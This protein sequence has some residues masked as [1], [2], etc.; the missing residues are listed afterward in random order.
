MKE[1]LQGFNLKRIA[2]VHVRLRQICVLQASEA[3]CGHLWSR[4][5]RSLRTRPYTPGKEI[6]M[7]LQGFLADLTVHLCIEHLGS[8]CTFHRP[9]QAI[10]PQY[11]L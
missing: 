4:A 9:S 5:A 11:V 3:A 6:P 7:C 1:I 8:F 10:L 2:N